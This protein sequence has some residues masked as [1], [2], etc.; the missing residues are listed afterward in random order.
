[1]GLARAAYEMALDYAKQ[2]V[3]WGRPITQ[4]QSISNMLVDMKTHI[5]TARLL[6][7]RLA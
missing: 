6:V 1:M 4:Y 5:E 7:R 2:R 3:I